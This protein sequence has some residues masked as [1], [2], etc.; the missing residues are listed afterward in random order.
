MLSNLT[1][2]LDGVSRRRA[3]VDA[4]TGAPESIIAKIRGL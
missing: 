4:A 1:Q 3:E 2:V